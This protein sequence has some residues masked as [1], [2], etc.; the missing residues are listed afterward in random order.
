MPVVFVLGL[1]AAGCGSSSGAPGANSLGPVT[2]APPGQTVNVAMKVLEFS[3]AA[4]GEIGR[5]HV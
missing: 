3:P 5:A 4:V 1:L 2:P